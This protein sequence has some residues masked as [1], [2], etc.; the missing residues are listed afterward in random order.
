MSSIVYRSVTTALAMAALAAISVQPAA[1]DV[2]Y[3]ITIDTSSVSGTSGFLDFQFNP[4]NAA[5]QAVTAKIMNFS[6]NGTLNGVPMITGDVASTLP[7]TVTFQNDTPLNEYF[8]GFNYGTTISFLLV[9]SGPALGSP[10]GTMAGS[11]FGVGLYDSGQNPILT[12]QGNTTGFAG[13]V[14]IHSDGTT[15]ATAFPTA[16]M[17]PSVVTLTSTFP[18]DILFLFL[19]F[20]YST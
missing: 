9:L 19:Y 14:D 4:G 3:Q 10:N 1:A 13:E 16:T 5:T 15:T 2:A 12:N 11:T 7:G 18:P 17:G 20:F 8:Q 6:T